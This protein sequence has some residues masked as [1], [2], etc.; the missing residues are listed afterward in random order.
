MLFDARAALAVRSTKKTATTVAAIGRTTNVPLVLQQPPQNL[1][2]GVAGNLRGDVDARRHL[3]RREALPRELGDL[4]RLQVGSGDG[5]HDG[6]HGFTRSRV[7]D[8][9]DC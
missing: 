6:A 7:A 1:A 4:V 8:A 9:D 5:N 2:R 3:V